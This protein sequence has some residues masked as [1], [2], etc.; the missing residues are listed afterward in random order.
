MGEGGEKRGRRRGGRE[1]KKVRR[2]IEK[3]GGVVADKG[4]ME[5]VANLRVCK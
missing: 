1:G 2:K 5:R 4:S 3:E